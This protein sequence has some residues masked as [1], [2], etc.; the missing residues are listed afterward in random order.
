VL[1]PPEAPEPR[2]PP[3]TPTAA[4]TLRSWGCFSPERDIVTV[5]YHD[6]N[7][8]RANWTYHNTTGIQ[9]FNANK[10]L[11]LVFAGVRPG[12]LPCDSRRCPAWLAGCNAC[13]HG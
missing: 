8:E 4:A 2:R 9:H 3:T 10:T 1:A 12:S 13:R 11:L 6:M 5:P 7:G